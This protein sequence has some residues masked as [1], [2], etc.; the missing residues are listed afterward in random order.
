MNSSELIKSLLKNDD[1]KKIY[2]AWLELSPDKKS[3]EQFSAMCIGKAARWFDSF[4]TSSEH[5]YKQVEWVAGAI[6]KQLRE[7]NARV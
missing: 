2:E 1:W 5:Q 4:L 6:T 3:F 7:D